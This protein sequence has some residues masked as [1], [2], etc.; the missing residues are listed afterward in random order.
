[1]NPDYPMYQLLQGS[2]GVSRRF[3][4]HR[5]PGCIKNVYNPYSWTYEYQSPLTYMRPR[6]LRS[7]YTDELLVHPY[8]TSLEKLESILPASVMR[9]TTHRIAIDP[10]AE[11][12][13]EEV[14]GPPR[15]LVPASAGESG[16][17][18][19]AA[20]RPG[21]VIRLRRFE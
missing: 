3:Y 17:I 21:E 16:S 9:N 18:F 8:F 2:F 4:E 13:Q 20:S 12:E 7:L 6:P 15:T 11:E 14:D 1:M 10:N 19:G 5:P